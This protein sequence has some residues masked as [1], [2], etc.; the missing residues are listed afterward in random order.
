MFETKKKAIVRTID[1]S[2]VAKTDNAFLKASLKTSA[3]TTKLGNN[4]LKFETTGDDFIDQFGKCTIYKA[5]R[6]FAEVSKDMQLLFSQDGLTT[7]KLT[8][9]LRLIT[10]KVDFSDGT[11]TEY[12]QR[13]QGLR[14][15]GIFRM[16]WLA[17]NQPSVFW[18]NIHIFVAAGSWKDIITMLQYDLVYNGWDARK[19]DW[20]NFGQLLLAGL[21][22]C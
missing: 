15:E 21:D 4:A 14:H 12:T 11:T 5:P 10:R 8:V 16:I 19:L 17:I 1:K 20:E 3:K 18:K 9:Y 22:W 13:G 2:T 6:T 7:A